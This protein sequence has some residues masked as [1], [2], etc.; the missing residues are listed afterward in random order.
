MFRTTTL[1][2]VLASISL[3]AQTTPAPVGTTVTIAG[4]LAQAQR[5]G[6]LGQKASGV[7]ATPETAANEANNPEPTNR[8][9]LTSATPGDAARLAADKPPAPGG[10]TTGKTTYALRGQEKELASH[11]GHRVQ[12]EGSLLP[13]L[14]AKVPPKDAA[15]AEGVRTVQVVSVTMLGTGCS[16]PVDPSPTK[17]P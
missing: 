9:V 13:P 7:T 14:V 17:S 2:A 10:G 1:C 12:I 15:T 3:S 4:C 16:I 5:D 6:S 8:Y 11:V